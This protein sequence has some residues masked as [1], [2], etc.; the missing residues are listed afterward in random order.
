VVEGS[1]ALMRAQTQH[2][3][4]QERYRASAETLKWRHSPYN[5]DVQKAWQELLG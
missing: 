3:S 5:P 4:S 2:T 1:A